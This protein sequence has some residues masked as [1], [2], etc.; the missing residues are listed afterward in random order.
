VKFQIN[1][2]LKD[3]IKIKRKSRDQNG[4]KIENTILYMYIYFFLS[5]FVFLES[6]LEK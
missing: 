4:K 1:T 6:K 3:P 2:T 5:F